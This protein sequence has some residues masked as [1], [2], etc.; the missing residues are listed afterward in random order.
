MDLGKKI[1]ELRKQKGYNRDTLGKV[2]GTSGAVIGRY[3]RGEIT[4]S[5]EI[6]KKIAEALE[7]SLDYLVGSSEQEIDKATL[8]RIQEVAK[9]S[10]KEKE[11]VFEFLDAFITKA[12]LQSMMH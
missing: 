12:K 1:A 4:P 9:L 11:L 6:A 2:V 3:E 5:V 7:V 8:K 10:P